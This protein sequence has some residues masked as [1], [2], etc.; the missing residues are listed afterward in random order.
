MTVSPPRARPLAD[1]TSPHPQSP[2]AGD[3]HDDGDGG[4]LALRRAR[5]QLGGLEP[6]R[7]RLRR[8][9]RGAVHALGGPGAEALAEP[10]AAVAAAAMG[11]GLA[12]SS[13]CFLPPLEM[14][15]LG[16]RGPFGGGL[17]VFLG[18]RVFLSAPAPEF[19]W[20]CARICKLFRWRWSAAAGSRG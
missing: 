15:L 12:V 11:S 4:A 19:Q 1:F 17:L 6:Q 13:V 18:R 5:E 3:L 9:G 8:R 10:A 16:G 2:R 14:I 7:R 20:R